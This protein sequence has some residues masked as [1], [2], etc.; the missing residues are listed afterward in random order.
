MYVSDRA[1]SPQHF[2][3]IVDDVLDDAEGGATEPL[4]VSPKKRSTKA[5]SA[6]QRTHCVTL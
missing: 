3:D 5:G 2:A 6:K 1:L 4:P